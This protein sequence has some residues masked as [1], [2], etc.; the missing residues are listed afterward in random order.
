MGTAR[1]RG[2][3]GAETS[4]GERE[5]HNTL[6]VRL[7]SRVHRNRTF[8]KRYKETAELRPRPACSAH[9]PPAT[10]TP[11]TAEGRRGRNRCTEYDPMILKLGTL[12]RNVGVNSYQAT[13]CHYNS[14]QNQKTSLY[15]I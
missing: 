3:G 8:E 11:V 4:G 10:D 9:A 14:T 1:R 12:E 13:L 2:R 5:L 15:F 6:T 7:V